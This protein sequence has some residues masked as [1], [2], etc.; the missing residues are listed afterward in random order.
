[1]TCFSDQW[2]RIVWV[3]V[4][5]CLLN[6]SEATWLVSGAGKCY[7]LY[8]KMCSFWKMWTVLGWFSWK[9][10]RKKERT[11][12]LWSKWWSTEVCFHKICIH[13]GPILKDMSFYPS[14]IMLGAHTCFEISWFIKKTEENVIMVKNTCLFKQAAFLLCVFNI[15]SI[16]W[17][18]QRL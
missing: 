16:S 1:M 3:L 5:M 12:D 11:I 10:K 4:E 18:L 17:A 15:T 2:P 7:L 6:S 8:W 13:A 9:F 14:S